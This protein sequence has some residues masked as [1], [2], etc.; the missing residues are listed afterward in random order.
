MNLAEIK[1]KKR[2]GETKYGR[3]CDKHRRRGHDMKAFRNPES[4]RYLPLDNCQMCLTAEATDRHR[5]I[6]G[7]E[8]GKKT[9]MG[10]CQP[11]HRKIHQLY[12]VLRNQGYGVYPNLSD[13]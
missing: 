8:Y 6:P 13:K 3:W 9:V 7:S 2:N 12:K 10:L 5:I 4:K 1:G 11:C